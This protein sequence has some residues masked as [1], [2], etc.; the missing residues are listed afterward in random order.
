MFIVGVCVWCLTFVHAYAF[1]SK[2]IFAG[3]RLILWRLLQFLLHLIFWYWVSH[4]IG[5]FF[6]VNLDIQW[7][8]KVILWLTP[9][10]TPVHAE[11]TDIHHYTWHLQE[12]WAFKL[13]SL[14]LYCKHFPQS[15]MTLCVC[16]ISVQISLEL[17]PLSLYYYKWHNFVLVI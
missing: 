6:S 10:P 17:L 11:I 7:A 8:V 3:L 9:T 5:K 4:R 16:C 2:S 15:Y 14:S 13:K 12:C 1:I